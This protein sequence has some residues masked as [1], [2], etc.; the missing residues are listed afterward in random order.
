MLRRAGRTASWVVSRPESRARYGIDIAFVRVLFVLAAIFWIGIPVYIVAWIIIPSEDGTSPFDDR[1]RDMGLIVG[2]ALIAIGSIIVVDHVLPNGW[3][4]GRS[5]APLLLI[6]GGVAILWLRRPADD[7]PEPEPTTP[8]AATAHGPKRRPT[9]TAQPREPPTR[10]PGRRHPPSRPRRRDHPTRRGVRGRRPTRGRTAATCAAP[11][12][13]H[14]AHRPR[15]FLGPLTLSVLFIGAGIARL[16]QATG[17]VDINLTVALGRH[18]VVGAMLVVSAWFGRARS[19]IFLGAPARAATAIAS[20]IDVPLSGGIRRGDHRP[21][22]D[23]AVQSTYQLAPA[24][25]SS[26]C[27]TCRS[28]PAGPHQGHDRHRPPRNRRA[29][30]GRIVVDADTGAGAVIVFGAR[31]RLAP[32]RARSG[33]PRRAACCT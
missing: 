29:E 23:A 11:R 27:G 20:V 33:R 2:L 15:S 18:A 7:D 4:H 22:T 5:S 3:H 14:R 6:A 16:L 32:R 30:P 28:R 8:T 12:A 26:I 1:P 13:E 9:A 19:L 21:T 31:R 17:A 10:P 24:I 25:S